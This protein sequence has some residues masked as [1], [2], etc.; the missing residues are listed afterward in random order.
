MEFDF[1][2]AKVIE[3]QVYVMSKEQKRREA[4]IVIMSV[5]F[6]ILLLVFIFWY[7][8][9]HKK[10]DVPVT[11]EGNMVIDMNATDEERKKE[12]PLA[13]RQV[14]FAGIEDAVITKDGTVSLE[15]LE[16]NKEFVMKYIVTNNDTGEKIY[17]TD[18]I[19]SGQR[20]YWTPGKDLA[21]GEYNIAFTEMPYA[22]DATGKNYTPLT[23]GK[24][25]IKLTIVDQ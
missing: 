21:P 12:N 3:R 14:Y 11:Q 23:Q 25:V 8:K 15:N 10:P 22:P 13:N 2:K 24:N 17:E 4:A 19:P 9:T 16:A 1:H 18:L 20:I 5:I 7:A 6:V